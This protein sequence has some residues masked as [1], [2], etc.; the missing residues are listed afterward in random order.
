MKRNKASLKKTEIQS[1]KRQH[2]DDTLNARTVYN[3]HS[4]GIAV[5]NVMSNQL[6]DFYYHFPI[7]RFVC[8][9]LADQYKSLHPDIFGETVSE[10]SKRILNIS[11]LEDPILDFTG[12][13]PRFEEK[14]LFRRL[15]YCAR[16]QAWQ[17]W[18]WIFTVIEKVQKNMLHSEHCIFESAKLRNALINSN[19]PLLFLRFIKLELL[20]TGTGPNCKAAYKIPLAPEGVLNYHY[21][22][23]SRRQW[24]SNDRYWLLNK[25]AN[26]KNFPTKIVTA[27]LEQEKQRA[28]DLEGCTLWGLYACSTPSSSTRNLVEESLDQYVQKLPPGVNLWDEERFWLPLTLDSTKRLICWYYRAGPLKINPVTTGYPQRSIYRNWVCLPDT[29]RLIVDGVE[30]LKSFLFGSL[31]RNCSKRTDMLLI[32]QLVQ[33]VMSRP[34]TDTEL[35]KLLVPYVVKTGDTD[36]ADSYLPRDRVRLADRMQYLFR[37]LQQT[38]LSVKNP[39]HFKVLLWVREFF[40]VKPTPHYLKWK[41]AFMSD[42]NPSATAR[43]EVTRA[44]VNDLKLT[45]HPSDETISLATYLHY[46]DNLTV[47]LGVLCACTSGE[48][49][50]HKAEELEQLKAKIRNS[51]Q[52]DSEEWLEAF[53]KCSEKK[54]LHPSAFNVIQ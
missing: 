34:A 28:K 4:V 6:K 51:A 17:A 11:N 13:E 50:N 43:E 32:L 2:I 48:R 27:I 30:D 44:I 26:F 36:F 15:L 16:N 45:L 1:A 33:A 10:S 46:C 24:N 52:P 42:K 14:K 35:W 22:C 29:E 5:F 40:P 18:T 8:R 41:L 3:S 37:S 19:D 31:L 21:S 39:K 9:G 7:L 53:E 38:F 23:F 25:N 20:Y 47:L 49:S 54:W 12:L